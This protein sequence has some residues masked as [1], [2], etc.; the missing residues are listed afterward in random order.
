MLLGILVRG[1]AFTTL[2]T[3]SDPSKLTDAR[4][5]HLRAISARSG[6]CPLRVRDFAGFEVCPRWGVV[7]FPSL[8]LQRGET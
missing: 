6:G 5:Q 3:G 7:L 2:A 8:V 4:P 1:A